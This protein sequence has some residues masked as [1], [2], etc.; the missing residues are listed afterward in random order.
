MD[1]GA[2]FEPLPNSAH[3]GTS[4]YRDPD[5]VFEPA[6]APPGC[7]PPT[8][9]GKLGRYSHRWPYFG[10]DGQLQGYQCRFDLP[11][12][13]EFRPLRYG[14]RYGRLGWHWKG[15]A[16]G[17]PLYRLPALGA[18]VDAP[19]LVVEGE[20]AADAADWA[21]PKHVV[22]SPMNG[23]QSPHRTDWSPLA[24]RIVTVW[25]DADEP[26]REFA[27]KV[28]KLAKDAGAAEVR[29]VAVPDG[30]PEG[31]DLADPPPEDWTDGTVKAALADA[32]L[33]DPDGATQGDYRVL[34]RRRGREAPGIYRLVEREDKESGEIVS[35]WVRFGSR[36]YVLADTR[37]SDGEA[38]GR[39]LGIHDRD[40]TVHQYA[41]PMAMMAGSG[42]VYRAELLHRGMTISAHP[43]AR[44]WLGDYLS[45]WR[46]S[47]QG[48][49]RR[50]HRLAQVG[51]RPARSHLWRY[52]GRD[53]AAPGDRH[54]S[55]F[56]VRAR[57]R[58]AH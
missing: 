58:L 28:A 54:G 50:S 33:F 17:R 43:K 8:A 42:E 13:K 39:L 5:D 23:A 52:P 35:E 41:M 19:V 14:V 27:L 31:W 44:T 45:T 48:A 57:S 7:E 30:V 21:L 55:A 37:N 56:G 2:A 25:P 11:D 32:E 34:H 4:G 9:H 1:F 38:W 10:A 22:V 47:A 16:D 18:Q 6:V 29:I 46:P 51:V 49:L 15:W 36:L 3:L 26:G 53:R 12:G 20:K 24:G 40:G